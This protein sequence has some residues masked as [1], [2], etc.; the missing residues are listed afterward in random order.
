MSLIV[1]N[2]CA[3]VLTLGFKIRPVPTQ[4]CIPK[5]PHFLS[6][7]IE[8]KSDGRVYSECSLFFFLKKKKHPSRAMRM[9]NKISHW[10]DKH[11]ACLNAISTSKAQK[12][13][14]QLESKYELLS[15]GCRPTTSCVHSINIMNEDCNS[16]QTWF[17]ERG[18]LSTTARHT[19]RGIP[20]DM[21]FDVAGNL[22]VKPRRQV[23]ESSRFTHSELAKARLPE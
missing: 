18:L 19:G 21:C 17:N 12:T 1:P 23:M 22:C 16:E 10:E 9:T 13:Q 4:V 7:V 14:K 3:T 11:I 15:M 6:L 8:K 2:K 5:F 20:I